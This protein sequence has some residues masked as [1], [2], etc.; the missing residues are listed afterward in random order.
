[1]CDTICAT[2]SVTAGGV[3]LF[4]K[5]SDRQRNEA[6]GIELHP[7][8]DHA[9]DA[10]LEC[11]YIRIPQARHTHAVLVSRP[12][13][14]WGAEIGANEHGVVAGN[15]TVH[16]RTPGPE[17]AAL[18]GMD[19]VRLGLERGRTAAEAVG[20]MTA[21][22]ERYGQGGDCGHLAPFYY[23]NGFIIA[24]AT[25]A[26]VLETVG[27][28]WLV[29]RAQGVRTI[30]NCYSI[31]KKLRSS[32]GLDGLIA[33]AGWSRGAPESYANAIADLDRERIGYGRERRALSAQRLESRAGSLTVADFMRVL[34]DHGPTDPA[35]WDPRD[36]LP[37]GLCVHGRSDQ[38][39]AQ[40]TGALVSQIDRKR[41][42]HWVTGGAAPCIS[43]FKPV[44]FGTS[45]P[46]Q[47]P[48][49][50][51]TFDARSTWWRH[52]LLHR[53]ALMSGFRE[54]LASIQAERDA[55]E[56][57]FI[58]RVDAVREGGSAADREHVIADCWQQAAAMED[59]WF[60]R[61]DP[62]PMHSHRSYHSSWAKLSLVAGMPSQRL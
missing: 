20:V 8:A 47:G 15:E 46:S 41:P 25:E 57:Q 32:A 56:A 29:E 38:K 45:L 2:P 30:S 31:E 21:L 11:T 26:Y 18:T 19:L 28:D 9:P 40:T 5:D 39:G 22:L 44:L 12:F 13:W 54:F 58:Q 35:R 62:K 48:T 52:E 27:R 51:G 55:L 17:P 10:Q 24:D 53:T 49:S 33:S 14:M 3:M 60:A 50:T 59:A 37:P 42:V 16:A 34:R 4:G 61:L 23:N 6:Q 43:I 1:M 7:A 36:E